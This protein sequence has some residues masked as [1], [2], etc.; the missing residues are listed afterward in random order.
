MSSLPIWIMRGC[1]RGCRFCNIGTGRPQPVD[2]GEPMRLAQMVAELKLNHVVVTSVNRDDL[3]DGG[4]SHFARTIE[5]IRQ[6]LPS[7]SIEILTPDFRN[8]PQAV[9]IIIEA[10]PDVFNF[11]IK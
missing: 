10:R 9:D 3:P 2:P 11:S 7:A 1:T 6:E 8:A 4:A 5:A